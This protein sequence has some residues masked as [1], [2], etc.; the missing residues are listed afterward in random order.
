M[1]ED[2]VNPFQEMPVDEYLNASENDDEI[3]TDDSDLIAV[4]ESFESEEE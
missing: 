3:Q 1:I 2:G 4:V